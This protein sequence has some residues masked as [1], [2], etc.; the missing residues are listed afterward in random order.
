MKKLKIFK[1]FYLLDKKQD[2]PQDLYY[3]FSIQV[4][5]SKYFGGV[6]VQTDKVH[7]AKT[8][9]SLREYIE[10]QCKDKVYLRVSKTHYNFY[11]RNKEDL[12]KI[13]LAFGE[14]SE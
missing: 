5:K 9:I 3:Q 6:E 11:F 1:N 12:V 13:Q 4:Y 8:L 14:L 10:K 7:E 2:F